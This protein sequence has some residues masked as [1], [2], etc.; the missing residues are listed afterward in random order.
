LSRGYLSTLLLIIIFK[1]LALRTSGF[2]AIAR[3]K[4]TTAI[5]KK[6]YQLKR[7]SGRQEPKPDGQEK[8]AAHEPEAAMH[9]PGRGRLRLNGGRQD[10]EQLTNIL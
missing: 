4:R 8:I 1:L 5:R 3:H 7:L 2:P 9:L 10:I 6:I